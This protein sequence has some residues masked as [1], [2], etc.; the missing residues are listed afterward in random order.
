MKAAIVLTLAVATSLTA[1]A[2][3]SYTTTTK[4]TG[5][6]AAA[7]RSTKHYLKGQKM[8]T[9]LGDTAIIMDF[10]A[11]TMTAINNSAKTYTVT[12]FSE[13]GQAI[14]DTNT[15]I[16]VDVRETGQKK[17]I[18]GFASRE[19]IMT[20]ETTM[21]APGRGSQKM[22]V[23]MDMWISSAVP[24]AGELRAFN[25]RNAARYPYAAMAGG[26]GNQGMAKAMADLQKK[27]SSMDGVPVLQIMKM[28]APGMEAQMAQA[29]KGMEQAR[30]QM[31]KM[32][33]DGGPGAA[34][35]KQQL[36][37]M[38][39]MGG[40]GGGMEITTESSA[41]STASIPDSVFAIPAGYTLKAK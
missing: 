39:A 21:D 25:L 41:F 1:L 15:D 18:N 29:Q 31:E 22:T 20:M 12:K 17:D 13:L 19:V 33:K 10:D 24:G 27:M 40:G 2:D 5:M 30:A 38:N 28:K 14:K 4:G 11:Q 8:K 3:F 32:V 23:E 16:K 7:N 35:A 26:G 37:R 36:E 6:M 9:D 34:M